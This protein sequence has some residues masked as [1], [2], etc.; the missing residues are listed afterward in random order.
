MKSV[1]AVNSINLPVYTLKPLGVERSAK[2][3][4][5][6][7]QGFDETALITVRLGP[8]GRVVAAARGRL[9]RPPVP[10][11]WVVSSQQSP[12]LAGWIVSAPS[13]RLASTPSP[14]DVSLISG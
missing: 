2:S 1:C 10:A 5:S 3:A 8:V 11:G 14:F 7:F 6:L 13:Y 9:R 4:D 12:V